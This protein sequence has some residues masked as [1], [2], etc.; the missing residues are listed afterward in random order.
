MVAI[1]KS[2]HPVR[3]KWEVGD[4]V[5]ESEVNQVPRIVLKISQILSEDSNNSYETTVVIISLE[6]RFF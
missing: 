6:I 4:T 2:L 3:S 1:L 5:W